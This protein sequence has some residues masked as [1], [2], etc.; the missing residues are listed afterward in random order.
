MLRLLLLGPY[1]Q[2]WALLHT[3][4]AHASGPLHDACLY[5]KAAM[6]TS[7]IRR[8]MQIRAVLR[9]RGL[10]FCDDEASDAGASLASEH[11]RAT[12]E[13]LRHEQLVA[14]GIAASS[15][16]APEQAVGE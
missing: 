2:S 11:A 16:D 6:V 13:A 3:C 14:A 12:A 4:S 5:V 15:T 1:L 9:S 7:S 8:I 10:E